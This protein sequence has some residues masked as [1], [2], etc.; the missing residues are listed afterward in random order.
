[1]IGFMR[2]IRPSIEQRGQE[3]DSEMAWEMEAPC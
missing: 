2:F 1:M 3:K